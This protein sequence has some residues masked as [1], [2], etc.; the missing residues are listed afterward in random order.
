MKKI[1]VFFTLV[2]LSIN[3]F[4]QW[5]WAKQIGGPNY[6][7]GGTLIDSNDNMYCAGIFHGSCYFDNDT[8]YSVG[9]ND[10]F[11]AKYDASHNELWAKRFGGNNPIN[12][13]EWTG[14]TIIDNVN[15]CIYFSG[16][17]YGSLLIDVFSLS[18]S[19]N[20]DIFLAKFDF[21][22]NCLW[23]KK[24]G[25]FPDDSPGTININSTGNIYWTGVLGGN[26]N[27]D[28]YSLNKGTFLA[29]LDTS[30][31]VIW[32]RNEM[33]GGYPSKIKIVNDVLYFCGITTNDTTVIDTIT[34]LGSNYVDCLIGKLDTAGNV[35]WAKR[36]GGNSTDYGIDLEMDANS[37]RIPS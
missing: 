36:F 4:S 20:L 15:N 19:G 11:L 35:F 17:F 18:A 5:Q 14:G 25:S 26:G 24:A 13:D 33:T 29:E 22:G 32:A 21:N 3:S 10:V 34:L 2:L 30:G 12:H 1:F 23:L 37:F 16:T 7:G 28:S 8:L 27:L 9:T 6:D 31:N